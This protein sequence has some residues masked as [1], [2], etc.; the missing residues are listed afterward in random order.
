MAPAIVSP[1]EPTPYA[2]WLITAFDRWFDAPRKE[3][4]VRMFEEVMSGVLGGAVN[5]EAFGLSPVD[6]VVVEADGAIEQSDSLKIVGEGV[7]ETGL[8]VFRHSFSDAL[9]TEAIRRRQTGLRGLGQACR[10]CALVHVCGGGLYAHR[11][12]P[13]TGF[14]TPSVYCYDLYTFITHVRSRIHAEMAPLF[15][16]VETAEASVELGPRRP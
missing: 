8:D 11:H 14:D 15:E 5:T 1:N 16:T 6:L 4:R 13:A 2:R 10:D 3:T 7:P 9:A 12:H